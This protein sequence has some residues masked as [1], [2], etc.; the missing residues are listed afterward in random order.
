MPDSPASYRFAGRHWETGSVA[1]S[2]ALQGVTAPH[3]GAPLSE[4]LLLGI[5][6]GIAVGYFTFHYEGYDPHVALLTRNTFDPL[7]TLYDRLAIV[8]DVRQ[9][10]DAAR[11]EAHLAAVLEEGG[12]P[13]VWADSFT[14]PYNNFPLDQ[15][16]WGAMPVVAVGLEGDT[17]LV[18]DRSAKP[19]QVA[20]EVLTQARGRV[21]QERFRQMELDAPD[22]DR[23]P[24]A[25][26]KGIWQCLS[27]YTEA[28]P[29]GKRENFGLA[30]LQNWAEKITNTRNKQGWSRLFARG[31]ALYSALLGTPWQP[32]VLQWITTWGAGDGAERGVYADFLDEAVR[33]LRRP[34]LGEAAAAFRASH[35]AWNELAGALVPAGDSILN[36]AH[37]LLL[38]RHALFRDEGDAALEQIRA[39]D[40]RLAQIRAEAAAD[41]PLSGAEVTA[42]QHEL[43][44]RVLA[45]HDLER[46]A[47]RLLQAA[48]VS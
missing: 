31:T 28:P 9:T 27:L 45:I 1:N 12:V 13:L 39:T 43:A 34:A 36:E 17:V 30:A 35:A 5:S 16:A 44:A 20:P 29:R 24:E 21:K 26:Q 38:R 32:G 15:R 47:V 18:A 8:R 42:L 4:S 6:G 48:M 25:V 23:L 7:T 11:A 46:K 41:F 14:L 22:L 10:A 37:A 40:T 2:L 3:T 33:I 19:F